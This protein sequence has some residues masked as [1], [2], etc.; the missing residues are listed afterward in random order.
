MTNADLAQL[1]GLR[2]LTSLDLT[3]NQQLTGQALS[4]LVNLPLQNIALGDT[5]LDMESIKTILKFPNLTTLNLSQCAVK[6]SYLHELQKLS[7][8]HNLYLESTKLAANEFKEIAKI[9]SLVVLSFAK[10]DNISANLKLLKPLENLSVVDLSNTDVRDEDLTVFLRM[11]KVSVLLLN[12]TNITS[13]GLM[14]LTRL[15]SL[16]TVSLNDCPNL[17]LKDLAALKS[18]LGPSSAVTSSRS[19]YGGTE[20]FLKLRSALEI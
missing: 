13:N 1:A 4:A 17:N 3:H 15:R 6:A 12:G 7:H 9:N 2:R 19:K 5:Q 10:N 14:I 20:K 18:A 16:K 11:P 8:L